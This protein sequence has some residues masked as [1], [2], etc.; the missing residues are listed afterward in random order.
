MRGPRRGTHDSGRAI[1]PTCAPGLSTRRRGPSRAGCRLAGAEGFS[2]SDATPVDLA[3]SKVLTRRCHADT[4]RVPT[5][6]STSQCRVLDLRSQRRSGTP[7]WPSIRRA[8]VRALEEAQAGDSGI[9]LVRHYAD[10]RRYARQA[11]SH[12]LTLTFLRRVALEV[13]A[14]S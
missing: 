13:T 5:T 3:I 2:A 9:Y 1:R 6:G 10:R 8:P 14:Q 7:E 12:T 4:V 11:G